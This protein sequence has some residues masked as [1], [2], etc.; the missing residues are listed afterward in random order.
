MI[1]IF[2]LALL[3]IGLLAAGLFVYLSPEFGGRATA[4]EQEAYARS[5]NYAEGKFTNLIPTSMRMDGRTMASIIRDY[6]RGVPH[7][8]PSVP[9]PVVLVDSAT[10]VRAPDTLTRVTWFGHSAVLLEIDGQ[11]LL[12][13]PM[14]G[15]VPAPHPWLGQSRFSE[16]L[17]ITIDQLPAIDAVLISHDHY[18]HLDYGSIRLLKVKVNDFYVPLG[19]GA[20]LRRWGVAESAIH[21]LN[22]WDETTRGDLNLVLT[23]A[24]HFSGR[25][26]T[27]RD[28]TLWGSWVI[29]GQQNTLYFSGDSGYGP[30]FA[31]IGERYGPFDLAMIECGQYDTRWGQIHMMP[32]ESAQAA[33]DLRAK[34]M[35][36][37][38]WGAFRL[39]LHS[40]TDPI[41]R[42]TARAPELNVSL[43]T[44]K[45]GEAVVVSEGSYPATDWWK[46]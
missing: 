30:H 10:I 21:E 39:A 6:V 13:D 16:G 22:W 18:D 23:P 34:R 9:P 36:P 12:L 5:D 35:L 14:L 31:E 44:P 41:E 24:R 33:V 27:D 43:T 1:G 28:A 29:R 15:E 17:P 4:A 11:R 45:I 3:A 40:W 25:G 42:V 7:G 19:V 8:V 20:H 38:H 2:G 26:L 32:E 37:I 46:D